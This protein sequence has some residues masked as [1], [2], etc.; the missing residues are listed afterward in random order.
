MQG[1]GGDTATRTPSAMDKIIPKRKRNWAED[2]SSE[3]GSSMEDDDSDSKSTISSSSDNS[4]LEEGEGGRESKK[5]KSKSAKTKKSTTIDSKHVTIQAI[6]K[7][8]TLEGTLDHATVREFQTFVKEMRKTQNELKIADRVEP[9]MQTTLDMMFAAARVEGDWRDFDDDT[10]FKH[11]KD[12]IKPLKSQFS[13]FKGDKER[14]LDVVGKIPFRFDVEDPRRHTE[15]ILAWNSRI[16]KCKNIEDL[17]KIDRNNIIKQMISKLPMKVP[18]GSTEH[19]QIIVI[20]KE[21]MDIG[22]FKTIHEFLTTLA[23][24]CYDIGEVHTKALKYC[25]Y[26]V[27]EDATERNGKQKNQRGNHQQSDH[28]QEEVSVTTKPSSQLCFGCGRL[29]NLGSDCLLKSHPDF[30][31][32]KRPWVKSTKGKAWKE[33]G[34]ET[35]P[36]DRCL[37]K[38][39]ESKWKPP[40]AKPNKRNNSS[41]YIQK[42]ATMSETEISDNLLSCSIEFLKT[43]I[44]CRALIDTGALHG[45]CISKEL[46]K[47]L[48]FLGFER[49]E[50][51]ARVCGATMNICTYTIGT[52]LRLPLTFYNEQTNCNSTIDLNFSILET[53]FDLI[54]GRPD[55]IAH[56]LLHKLILST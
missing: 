3:S 23:K 13:R 8:M 45:N 24:V 33:K 42:L 36:W 41:E 40:P 35:L 50:Q 18:R 4:S 11:L 30:N 38:S 48:E 25:L 56:E 9:A 31:G 44:R 12:V 7:T 55:I 29:H 34:V 5:K 39:D 21:L 43:R 26:S 10:F 20:S 37:R 28:K 27:S 2:P 47:R 1:S 17:S 19:S 15:Y 14:L 16:E 32:E 54:I 51:I 6:V 53:D 49:Q 52:C 46:A 22:K